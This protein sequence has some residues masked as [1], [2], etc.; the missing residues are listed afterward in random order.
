MKINNGIK[1]LNNI[2]DNIGVKGFRYSPDYTGNYI[3]LWLSPSKNSECGTLGIGQWSDINNIFENKDKHE[4]I[5]KRIT[6]SHY[7]EKEH[8]YIYN[9]SKINKNGVDF[10]KCICESGSLDELKMRLQLI[11]YNIC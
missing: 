2:L 5:L 4:D 6:D 7:M 10:L 1:I 3:T 11:G 9:Y 8:L